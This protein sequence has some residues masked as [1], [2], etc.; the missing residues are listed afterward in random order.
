[1][2]MTIGGRYNW[3]GQPE[4]L[5]YLGDNFSGNGYWHQFAKIDSPHVVW[6]EVKGGQLDQ[7]EETFCGCREGTCESKPNACRMAA[8]V[9]RRDRAAM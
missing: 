8:E 6:C 7:F 9:A 5:V 4:R 2:K 3:I 1:M